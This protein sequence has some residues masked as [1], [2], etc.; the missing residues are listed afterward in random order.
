MIKR[1]N[2]TKC[3]YYKDMSVLV[4]SRRSEKTSFIELVAY[5]R[6]K[7]GPSRKV[8]KLPLKYRGD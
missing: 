6:R 8:S 4:E 7:A 5:G 2:H 3:E 1:D